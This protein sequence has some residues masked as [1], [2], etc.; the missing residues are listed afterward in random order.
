VLKNNRLFP[1]FTFAL[2]AVT[3]IKACLPHGPFILPHNLKELILSTLNQAGK[4]PYPIGA[5]EAIASFVIVRIRQNQSFEIMW[6]PPVPLTALL[7]VHV[8][9]IMTMQTKGLGC[10]IKFVSIWSHSVD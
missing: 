3:W 1:E 4:D 5:G 9:S 6:Y 10:H 7:R 2:E 8:C